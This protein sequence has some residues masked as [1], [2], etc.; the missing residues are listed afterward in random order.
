MLQLFDHERW[1]ESQLVNDV[2]FSTTDDALSNI[3]K[4]NL[5]EKIYNRAKC[6]SMIF[7]FVGQMSWSI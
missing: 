3:E 6:V 2:S 7:F 1:S 4:N 5:I